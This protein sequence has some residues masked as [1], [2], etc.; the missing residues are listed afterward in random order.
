MVV[1]SFNIKINT[2]CVSGTVMGATDRASIQPWALPYR[3][4]WAPGVAADVNTVIR[5][6]KICAGGSTEGCEAC[7]QGAVRELSS[8]GFL[9]VGAVYTHPV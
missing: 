7:R 4:L 9:A 1:H 2:Y 5:V 3:S 6:N 8:S